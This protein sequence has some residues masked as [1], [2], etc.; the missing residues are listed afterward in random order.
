MLDSRGGGMAHMASHIVGYCAKRFGPHVV[1]SDMMI[2]A[3]TEWAGE[4][5]HNN[6][7]QSIH[8]ARARHSA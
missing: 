6:F 2:L 7:A 8:D 3:L 5:T 4:T 1:P